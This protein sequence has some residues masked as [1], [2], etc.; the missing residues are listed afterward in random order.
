VP[1]VRGVVGVSMTLRAKDHGPPDARESPHDP[2]RF[3]LA[4]KRLVAGRRDEAIQL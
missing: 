4:E 2:R 1:V 3:F